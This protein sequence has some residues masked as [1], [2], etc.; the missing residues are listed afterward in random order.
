M[1]WNEGIG[2]VTNNRHQTFLTEL[3]QRVIIG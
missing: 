3:L 2:R 1:T